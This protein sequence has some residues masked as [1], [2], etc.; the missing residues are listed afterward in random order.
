MDVSTEFLAQS[1]GALFTIG[2]AWGIVKSSL[3]N[4]VSYGSHSEICDKVQEAVKADIADL[5]QKAADSYGMIKE[6]H[7]YIKAKNG[8]QL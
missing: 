8:G 5:R 6:I 1:G 4:K 7:G 2:V 3:R